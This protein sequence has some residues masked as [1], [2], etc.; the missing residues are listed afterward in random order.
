MYVIPTLMLREMWKA[1]DPD[2]PVGG[3]WKSRDRASPL[4]LL[5]LIV[6]CLPNF[7]IVAADSDRFL[8]QFEGGNEALAELLTRDRAADWRRPPHS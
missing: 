5:W 7:V 4:P 2:V 8:D 3:D 1:S 6:Y